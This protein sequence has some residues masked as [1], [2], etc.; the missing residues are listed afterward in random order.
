MPALAPG[1][2]FFPGN[3][4]T[5][6]TRWSVSGATE[7]RFTLTV[8]EGNAGVT[9]KPVFD[10]EV[11]VLQSGV[12]A[13]FS[14]GLSAETA[15]FYVTEWQPMNEDALFIGEIYVAIV[16]VVS[17]EVDSDGLRFGLAEVQ[18]R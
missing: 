2:Y 14:S 4:N 10:A 13:D 15:G 12:F 18:I 11:A 6:V 1:T 8:L 7:C 9:V 3:L 17:E 16:V 5:Y